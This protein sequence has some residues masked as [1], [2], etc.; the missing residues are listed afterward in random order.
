MN[1][2]NAAQLVITPEM[3]PDAGTATTRLTFLARACG[4]AC[5][6]ALTVSLTRARSGDFGDEVKQAASGTFSESQQIAAVKGLTAAFIY[7]M[8]V[9]FAKA[10]EWLLD[11]LS[12]STRALD[13]IMPG[14]PTVREI[15]MSHAGMSGYNII[16]EAASEACRCLNFQRVCAQF[17]PALEEFL[18]NSGELRSDLL[19]YSLVGP[20]TVIEAKVKELYE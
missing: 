10:P 20:M 3:K 5:A 14:Q 19:E 4:E 18:Q 6:K 11:F 13:R 8:I 15:L 16:P 2:P 9:D 17:G 12:T 7:L 1:T